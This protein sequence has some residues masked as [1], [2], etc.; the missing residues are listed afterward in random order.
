M[1][2][3][4]LM[5]IAQVTESDSAVYYTDGSV[6][7]D[8]GR[9]GAEAITRGTELCER[10]SNHCSTLPTELVAIQLALEHAH[11][12][13]EPTV[14]LHRLQSGATGHPAAASQR[15]CGPHHHHSGYPPEHRRA[16][17]AGEAQLDP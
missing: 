17:A 7:P 5:A 13:Q 2:Q 4:A 11:H 12:Q 3:H 10:T 9:K 15:Q 8:S 14:M 6:D 16:G 1:R